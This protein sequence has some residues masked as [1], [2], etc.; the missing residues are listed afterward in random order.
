MEVVGQLHAQA[1]VARGKEPSNIFS[2]YGTKKQLAVFKNKT[3]TR[4][5]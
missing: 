4:I 3:L 5:R 1:T 2:L